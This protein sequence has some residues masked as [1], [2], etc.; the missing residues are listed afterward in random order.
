[1]IK[2]FQIVEYKN[3][4]MDFKMKSYRGKQTSPYPKRIPGA[5][6]IKCFGKKFQKS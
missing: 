4:D 5:N 1:M 2:Q 3:I 6:F